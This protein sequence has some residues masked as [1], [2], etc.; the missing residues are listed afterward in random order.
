MYCSCLTATFL[1]DILNHMLDLQAARQSVNV[2]GKQTKGK[3]GNHLMSSFPTNF[4]FLRDGHKESSA[5]ESNSGSRL[6]LTQ[7]SCITW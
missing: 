4:C 7:N 5:G 2:T 3:W 6:D 1:T